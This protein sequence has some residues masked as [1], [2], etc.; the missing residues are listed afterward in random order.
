MAGLLLRF[1]L[2]RSIIVNPAGTKE[3]TATADRH[4]V[5]GVDVSTGTIDG[6][7]SCSRH[8]FQQTRVARCV[9]SASI[10]RVKPNGRTDNLK[11]IVAFDQASGQFVTTPIDLG[12][13]GELVFLIVYGTGWRFRSSLAAASVTIDGVI[14]EVSYLGIQPDYVG[15]DQS[16]ILLPRTLAGR[17]EVDVVMT[18]NGKVSNK[19]RI[20]IK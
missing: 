5:N 4:I 16:N 9:A 10:I 13:E 6:Y 3:G 19:V 1:S 18:V 11:P 8:S 7:Y 17:G 12:P 20:R 14:G 2:H 15:L